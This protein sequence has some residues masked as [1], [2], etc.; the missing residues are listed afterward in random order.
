MPNTFMRRA[1]GRL[2]SLS[3]LLLLAFSYA[4]AAP[5]TFTVSANKHYW[6]K[7]GVPFVTVGFNRYDVWNPT[8]AANDGLTVTQ[9]VQRMAQNGANV[10]RVWA[11]QGDQNASGDYW[12]EYPAGVY[13]PAQAARLDELFDA[14]DAY[15]VYVMIC[16]WDTYN[17]K[18]NWAAHAYNAANGGPCA[19]AAEVIT[20]PNARARVKSKIQYMYNRWGSRRSFFLWTFNEIDILNTNSAA[21]QDFARDVGAYIKSIDPYHPFTVSFTGTGAGNPSVVQLPEVSAADIHFY[22]AITGTGGAA[23][24]RE[25]AT[26]R[27]GGYM[28]FGK[29][30][31][32]SEW[33]VTRQANSDDVVNALAW[34]GVAIGTGGAGMVWTDKYTYGGIKAS[35]LAILKSLRDFTATV[36]WPAFMDNHHA[37]ASEVTDTASAVNT[38]A[39]LNRTQAVVLLVHNRVGSSTATAVTVSGLNPGTYTVDVWRTYAG[40][41]HSTLTA[42]TNAQGQ[43]VISAP[44]IPT[45]QALYVHQ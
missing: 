23:K 20:D 11:E 25:T 42:A 39:C 45:M 40:G 41:K 10:I 29:P 19:T 15:G 24:E 18:N 6:L 30:L 3:C 35:H 16:P 7:D 43:L 12:L 14:C 27:D 2:L 26:L 31:V 13:R 22:G 33:G 32:L 5:S 38:F 21:Q 1:C 17:V 44:A 36:D 34:G 8:D 9:Y 4:P 28:N 37:G